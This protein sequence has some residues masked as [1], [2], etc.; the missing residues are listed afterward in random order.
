MPV[1]DVKEGGEAR[2]W[3]K[4]EEEHIWEFVMDL[5]RDSVSLNM[6]ISPWGGQVQRLLI[7]DVIQLGCRFCVPSLSQSIDEGETGRIKVMLVD[8]HLFCLSALKQ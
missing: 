8:V 2:F 7:N 6:D 4:R 1:F 5:R 3:A